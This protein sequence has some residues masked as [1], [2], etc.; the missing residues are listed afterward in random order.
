MQNTQK[1]EIKQEGT[2]FCHKKAQKTQEEKGNKGN[3]GFNR[4]ERK[5]RRFLTTKTRRNKGGDRI[6]GIY[7]IESGNQELRYGLMRI[8]SKGRE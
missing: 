2:E 6:N 1:E 3:G 5:E 8:K 7:R 4:R